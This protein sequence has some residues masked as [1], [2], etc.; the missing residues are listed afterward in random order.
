MKNENATSSIT[1]VVGLVIVLALGAFY[2]VIGHEWYFKGKMVLCTYNE[3]M[4]LGSWCYKPYPL[5]GASQGDPIT[6][7][8]GSIDETYHGVHEYFND[9]I[10]GNLFQQIGSLMMKW[11][12]E[13]M[14]G[15]FW[16]E[17]AP[18]WNTFFSVDNSSAEGHRI[19]FG[20]IVGIFYGALVTKVIG[21]LLDW[22]HGK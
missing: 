15:W 18:Q 13:L 16:Q 14:N 5:V 22:A 17:F 19:A 10:I 1:R 11:F 21:S 9:D 4:K 2:V 6:N 12:T 3:T 8:L 7:S 20:V